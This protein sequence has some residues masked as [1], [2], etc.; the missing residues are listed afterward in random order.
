LGLD[1]SQDE[2]GTA[3][4]KTVELDDYLGG[5]PIQHREVQGFESSTFLAYFPFFTCL[6]GGVESGF[7][8]VSPTEYKPRL[9]QVSGNK[10]KSLVIRQVKL[11]HTS[12]NSGDVFILDAG[13]QIYQW[14]GSKASGQEKHKSMEFTAALSGERKGAKV[15]VYGTFL[16]T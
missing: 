15:T 10:G 5:S 8:K 4:Y 12:L 11:S 13:L 2:A 14:N 6:Q 9:F 16:I 7:K 3:A 1:T